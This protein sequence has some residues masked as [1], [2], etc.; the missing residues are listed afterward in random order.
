[1]SRFAETSRALAVFSIK[2]DVDVERG[3]SHG[4]RDAD[5]AVEG[6]DLETQEQGEREHEV[7]A[8][9]GGDVSENFQHPPGR[10]GHGPLGSPTGASG[11]MAHSGSAHISSSIRSAILWAW[12]RSCSTIQSAA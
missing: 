4:G 7:E 6:S 5:V 10:R 8:G 11:S 12:A 1:M 2:A 3:Q 9:E